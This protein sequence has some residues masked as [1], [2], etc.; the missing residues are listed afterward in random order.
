MLPPTSKIHLIKVLNFGDRD[1][2][3]HLDLD[4]YEVFNSSGLKKPLWYGLMWRSHIFFNPKWFFQKI[5][6]YIQIEAR[7]MYTSENCFGNKEMFSIGIWKC[8]VKYFQW[9]SCLIY[10]FRS[11]GA[12]G[13]W[14][15]DL[16]FF[17]CIKWLCSLVSQRYRSLG[18][19]PF[20]DLGFNKSEINYIVKYFFGL[21]GSK[22]Q[23]STH[24]QHNPM[25]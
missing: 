20:R 24:G 5:H 2:E 16:W 21:V 12:R 4:V 11:W 1:D 3:T 6:N 13:V 23:P 10:G 15:L 22:F 8:F 17:W 25:S 7:I 18:V 19:L 14:I 9:K